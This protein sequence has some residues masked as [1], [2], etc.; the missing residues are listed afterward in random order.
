MALNGLFCADVPLRTYSLS[1]CA[2]IPKVHGLFC[3]D[4]PLRTYSLSLSV[5][6]FQKCMAAGQL[7]IAVTILDFVT[8]C[9]FLG[10]FTFWISYSL[11]LSLSPKLGPMISQKVKSFFVW[12]Q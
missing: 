6:E 10:H 12:T 5:P 4:V 3:A 7:F 8:S 9:D 2:R 1:L 11:R